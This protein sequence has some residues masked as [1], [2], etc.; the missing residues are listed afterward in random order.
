LCQKSYDPRILDKASTKPSNQITSQVSTADRG[1]IDISSFKSSIETSL[2]IDSPSNQDSES[3]TPHVANGCTHIELPC[4]EELKDDDM[5][6]TQNSVADGPAEN[7]I[8]K[9]NYKYPSWDERFNELVAFKRTNGHTN[10][11]ATSQLGKWITGQRRKY[12]LLR[13][14]DPQR[15]VVKFQE[16]EKILGCPR[17]TP[18]DPSS[19]PSSS[20]T[21]PRTNKKIKKKKHPDAP[22]RFKSAFIFFSTEKH[23][24]IRNSITKASEVKVCIVD[25]YF[26]CV[27]Y[28]KSNALR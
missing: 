24:E 2:D 22:R 13:E 17:D 15:V 12:R 1:D 19:S 10:V 14:E 27:M 18:R 9:R 28:L 20:S 6:Q 7:T 25:M 16:L 23:Q 11:I 26:Y 8:R 3:E 4:E 21:S 5:S